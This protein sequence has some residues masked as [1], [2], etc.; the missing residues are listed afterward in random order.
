MRADGNILD[1]I[2]RD[3]LGDDLFIWERRKIGDQAWN[4]YRLCHTASLELVRDAQRTTGRVFPFRLFLR[5][6]LEIAQD[7]KADLT[8]EPGAI[9]V[10]DTAVERYLV[11][12]LEN[13]NL[14]AIHAQ[15]NYVTPKDIQLARRMERLRV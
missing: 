14:N 2:H 11:E 12:L 9:D 10:L 1:F 7:F 8:W 6:V 5:L 15:R 13:A 4:D 3:G